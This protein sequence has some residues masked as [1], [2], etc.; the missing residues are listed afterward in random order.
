MATRFQFYYGLDELKP[1]IIG[2][3]LGLTY[4]L[5][6]PPDDPYDITTATDAPSTAYEWASAFDQGFISQFVGTGVETFKCVC[7]QFDTDNPSVT[8]DVFEQSFAGGAR[9]TGRYTG[10]T[11]QVFGLKCRNPETFRPSILA[12]GYINQ[13][14]ETLGPSASLEAFANPRL[15]SL[16]NWMSDSLRFCV[17]TF[18]STAPQFKPLGPFSDRMFHSVR[19]RH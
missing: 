16:Y 9:L 10:V 8:T 19:R 13:S 3:Y 6:A 15:D 2:F 4:S 18:D 5:V 7:T 12:I 11:G 1:N 14:V 17:S